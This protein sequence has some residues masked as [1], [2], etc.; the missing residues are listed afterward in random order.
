VAFPFEKGEPCMAQGEGLKKYKP[1][2]VK[3]FN[4]ENLSQPFFK[5]HRYLHIF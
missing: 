1:N 3:I 5:K 2:M 4:V